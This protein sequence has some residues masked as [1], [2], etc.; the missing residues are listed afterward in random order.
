MRL[1]PPAT[2]PLPFTS[3]AVA[4]HA[5]AS[6]AVPFTSAPPVAVAAACLVAGSNLRCSSPPVALPPAPRRFSSS[7]V[8]TVDDYDEY[9]HYV[10]GLVGLGLSKLFHA[11]A[12]EDLALD[13]LSNSMGLSFQVSKSHAIFSLEFRSSFCSFVC[14]ALHF[15]LYEIK[16]LHIVGEVRL[17]VNHCLL[18]LPGVRKEELKRV[19]SH[20]Q[21]VASEGARDTGAVASARAAEIY[22]LDVLAEHIQDN[23]DNVTWFLILARELMI[24]ITDRLHKTS[25][26]F[27][28]E[29][30]PGV[31][32]KALACFSLRDINLSKKKTKNSFYT[33]LLL[34]FLLAVVY[35]LSSVAEATKYP[36]A[37]NIWIFSIKF[38][39][40]TGHLDDRGWK[41][42]Y[43]EDCVHN[44]M[45]P[46]L[47]WKTSLEAE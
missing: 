12:T 4:S 5:V 42:V 15:M 36:N 9:C 38:L 46:K 45:T 23:S 40:W 6:H 2:S 7:Q 8:E 44:A 1:T 21:M 35:S 16:R 47:Y 19:L 39:V 26:V 24:P 43:K 25:I 30:G 11:S 22:G 37:A 20:P 32:F 29:E 27:T 13:F 14:E 41:P 34:E 33:P 10:V 17:L 3:H 18:G 31:L 28:L